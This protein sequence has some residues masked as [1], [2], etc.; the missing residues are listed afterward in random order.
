MA[1]FAPLEA[2]I[3]VNISIL[4]GTHTKMVVFPKTNVLRLQKK[5]KI[6]FIK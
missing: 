1:F 6:F 3:F 5:I 4:N 2:E